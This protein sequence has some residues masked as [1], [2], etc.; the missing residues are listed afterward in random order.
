[1]RYL[2]SYLLNFSASLLFAFQTTAQESLKVDQAVFQ[3]LQKNLSLQIEGINVRNARQ[4]VIIEEAGFDT[5]LFASASHRG[6]R[7]P[8]FGSSVGGVQTHDS[9]ARIGISKLINTGAE[10]EVSTNYLRQSDHPGSPLLNPSH[11]SDLSVS[12][13]Q[14]LLRGAGVEQNLIPVE[15]AR[16]EARRSELI[17][18]QVALGIMSDTEFAYWELAYAHEVKKVREAS[19]E[20]AEKL[21]EENQERERVGFATNIDVLQSQVFVATSQ[22]AVIFA[23]ALI[24]NSQ[25][26]L[27]RQ[28]GLVDYPE[29]FVHV[30]SLP[31]LSTEETGFATALPTILSNSPNYQQQSLVVEV[32]ELYFKSS[33]NNYL[34]RVDL[35]TGVGFSGLDD[36]W[37]SAYDNTLDREGYNWSAGIEFSVPW[38]QRR[39]KAILQQTENNF[40]RQKIILEDLRRQIQVVNRSNWRNWVTGLE[41]VKAAKVS[42]DLATEQFDRE[43]TKYSSG[44]S[45]FRELLQA[46]D[47]QDQANLRYLS[48]ILEAI[49]SKIIN[50]EL[51]A[52]L[53]GRYGLTWESTAN[54][55]FPQQEDT[56]S[57]IQY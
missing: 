3:A 5:S 52:S 19:L 4:D 11:A 12:L 15:Q 47:D 25:D 57:D 51:D 40:E 2:K 50:M 27:I 42:L 9:L 16:I 10:L 21:L 35:T 48:S 20:V 18:Q 44:L 39:D 36:D 41:R 31:D 56:N 49:K 1:M 45:T 26:S 29:D 54:L 7:S 32:W 55:V 33:R 24:R 38:G 53:P 37:A 43:Q 8:R 46:R 13:R 14:P 17:L 6:S 22:E 23:D 34:P 30:D 28:M